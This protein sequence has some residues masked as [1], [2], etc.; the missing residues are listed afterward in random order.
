MANF[1]TILIFSIAI[2]SAIAAFAKDDTK[3]IHD[4]LFASKNLFSK[5]RKGTPNPDR[6]YALL[7]QLASMYKEKKDAESLEKSVKIEALIETRKPSP[8]KC[9]FHEM[10]RQTILH[11]KA[12]LNI[13]PYLTDNIERLFNFCKEGL[14]DRLNQALDSFSDQ[15]NDDME[16]IRLYVLYGGYNVK[17]PLYYILP[18]AIEDGLVNFLKDRA[19]E[20]S[21]VA[22][23][24][25]TT[26]SKL[27][28][29]VVHRLFRSLGTFKLIYDEGKRPLLD[30]RTTSWLVNMEICKNVVESRP[31]LGQVV[32]K[33]LKGV[34]NTSND[35]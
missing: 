31:E 7:L 21:G 12:N 25:D 29:K 20:T 1:R 4:E 6:T 13:I 30:E 23:D 14:Y 2:V 24:Y 15:E 32:E 33:R 22:V 18:E 9:N 11:R 26:I 34:K 8:E 16:K 19:K 17:R 35:K 28:E 5:I 3:A 10:Y 27:C